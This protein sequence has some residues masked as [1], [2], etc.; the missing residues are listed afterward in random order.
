MTY[1]VIRE[2]LLPKFEEKV[3]KAINTGYELYGNLV[4]DTV[5]APDRIV[6]IFHQVLIKKEIKPK[7]TV[8]ASCL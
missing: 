5:R 3:N 4:I 8:S 7:A 2:P 6:T 1:K